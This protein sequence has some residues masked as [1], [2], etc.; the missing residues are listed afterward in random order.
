MKTIK[1]TLFDD[2]PAI[3]EFSSL[4]TGREMQRT[5]RLLDVEN[6]RQRREYQ[7]VL[8]TEQVRNDNKI[9]VKE[10]KDVRE[11]EQKSEPAGLSK[12]ASLA[13]AIAGRRAEQSG[14]SRSEVVPTRTEALAG[15]KR[16]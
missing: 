8:R 7:R 16:S 12:S 1:I 14:E 9:E 11:P 13:G 4:L 15:V 6:G 10:K 2:K 3:C 5:I